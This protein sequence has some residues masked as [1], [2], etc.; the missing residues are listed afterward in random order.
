ME[1][2]QALARIRELARTEAYHQ[3]I[4]MTFESVAKHCDPKWPARLIAEG[5]ELAGFP[6]WHSAPDIAWQPY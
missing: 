1:R 5:C 3:G 2:E 4:H 6:V